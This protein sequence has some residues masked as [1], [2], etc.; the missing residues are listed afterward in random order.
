MSFF[1]N[2]NHRLGY[3]CSEKHY[4][5]FLS[6]VENIWIDYRKPNKEVTFDSI[7][8]ATQLSL[9]KYITRAYADECLFEGDGALKIISDFLNEESPRTVAQTIE[10]IIAEKYKDEIDRAFERAAEL[11]Q[12]EVNEGL[13]NPFSEYL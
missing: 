11:Y 3:Q 2:L 13:H 7:S 5:E 10:K 12:I 4:K 6:L 9:L 8:H 1:Y